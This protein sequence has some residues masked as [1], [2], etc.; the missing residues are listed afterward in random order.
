MKVGVLFSGG[1]DS[2][3][4]AFLAKEKGDELECLVTLSPARSDSYMF[5]YPNIRWTSMQAQAMHLPQVTFETKG[6]KEEE[7][8]DLRRAVEIAKRDYSIEGVY[9]GALASVYQKSRVERIL[10][11][12]GLPSMPMKTTY[13]L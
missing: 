7:L 9:T 13:S 6:V 3:Y 4:A 2:T 5:H 8:A 1:K 11:V 12:R 10:M